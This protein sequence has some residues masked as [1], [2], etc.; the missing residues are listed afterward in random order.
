MFACKNFN[1]GGVVVVVVFFSSAKTFPFSKKKR[2][3]DMR[4]GVKMNVHTW[5]TPMPLHSLEYTQTNEQ[6]THLLNLIINDEK[7]MFFFSFI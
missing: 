4:Y 1:T 5:S 7:K 6:T 2:K 3:E